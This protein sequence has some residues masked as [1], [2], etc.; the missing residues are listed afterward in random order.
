M[1]CFFTNLYER[2][3][4][5]IRLFLYNNVHKD[6]VTFSYEVPRLQTVFIS[7]KISYQKDNFMF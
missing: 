4:T 7:G 1:L 2:L 6:S 5:L 3:I